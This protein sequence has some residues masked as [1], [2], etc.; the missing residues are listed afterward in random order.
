MLRTS[1]MLK[2]TE[3][4]ASAAY[5]VTGFF[6]DKEPLKWDIRN[7]SSRLVSKAAHVKDISADARELLSLFSVARA[8]G[9]V[10]EANFGI[11]S[12]E[13]SKFIDL[14]ENMP[15]HLIGSGFFDAPART[16]AAQAEAPAIKDK[17][18]EPALPGPV[19]ERPKDAP[20]QV[21]REFGA[22][23]VKKNS[24][25]SIII[26]LL[27]KKKE[28]MIK[29]VSPLIE[30]VSEKTIQREL[31]AMVDQGIVKKEGEK[32]WSRYSLA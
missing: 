12:G 20:R 27:K 13:V 15:A 14:S 29:D 28:I 32:R 18:S 19:H 3:K 17:Y 21:L 4:I 10:S 9:L 2:K 25:Q 22:V 30:G 1:D 16:E 6:D 26:G 24:R 7:L 11:L 5:L 31:L 23:A 8:A